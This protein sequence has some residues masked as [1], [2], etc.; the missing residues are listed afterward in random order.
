MSCSLWYHVRS[1]VENFISSLISIVYCKFL[2]DDI[3]IKT[4]CTIGT[5][6][7]FVCLKLP[8]P[9][10][11]EMIQHFALCHADDRNEIRS[12]WIKRFDFM[13]CC[14]YYRLNQNNFFCFAFTS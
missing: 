2:I 3:P 6:N 7:V 1:T 14:S 10:L 5:M 11:K 9:R 13:F 12:Y 8:F 4:V